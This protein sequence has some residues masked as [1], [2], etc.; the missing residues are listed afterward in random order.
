MLCPRCQ[1]GDVVKATVK[2]LGKGIFV[3]QECEATWFSIDDIGTKPFIDFGSY[4]RE[5][6]LRPV[7]DEIVVT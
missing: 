7:W 1:Q 5:N 4:M 6:G 3:C 2:K